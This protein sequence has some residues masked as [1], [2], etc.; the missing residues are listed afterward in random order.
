M[1]RPLLYLCAPFAT[2]TPD[3]AVA[4]NQAIVR[5]VALGWVPVYAPYL[6]DRFLR[7]GKPGERALA[8]E[9][10]LGLLD[11]ADALLVVGD[12]LTDGMRL[13]LKRWRG[14]VFFWPEVPPAETAA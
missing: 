5:A 12:R 11:R 6:L 10:A 8:L 2:R 1:N 4:T 3:E 9:C 13:E 7:D 14:S